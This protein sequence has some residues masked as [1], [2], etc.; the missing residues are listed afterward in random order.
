MKIINIFKKGQ[1]KDKEGIEKIVQ[2]KSLMNDKRTI[3]V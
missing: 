1:H 2:I 3:F